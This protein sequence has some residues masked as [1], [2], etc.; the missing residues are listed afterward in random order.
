MTEVLH[1]VEKCPYKSILV[2]FSGRRK[3]KVLFTHSKI[4][5]WADREEG[6]CVS[7]KIDKQ[8]RGM[9]NACLDFLFSAQRY[10][11]VQTTAS[12]I[13]TSNGSVGLC[14][15]SSRVNSNHN[16]P[17][18][19]YQLMLVNN[20]FPSPAEQHVMENSFNIRL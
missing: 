9:K 2:I 20:T 11:S 19:L 17:S 5:A 16:F 7:L 13:I 14:C 18:R 3:V 10:N 12:E 4:K 1:S 6:Q 15:R 8:C